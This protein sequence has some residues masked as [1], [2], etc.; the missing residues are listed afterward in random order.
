MSGVPSVE[1]FR[2]SLAEAA[3]ALA[4]LRRQG[5]LGEPPEGSPSWRVPAEAGTRVA[6]E[7]ARRRVAELERAL[8]E[9]LRGAESLAAENRR[10]TEEAAADEALEER[11]EEARARAADAEA[12]SKELRARAALLEAECVRLE[13]LRRKADGAAEEAAASG[14]AVAESL[15]REL[16]AAHAA[17]DR[18][19]SEAGHREAAVK[20]ETEALSKRL[21]TAVARLQS[22]E[23]E[24]RLEAARSAGDSSVVNGELE[25]AKAVGAALRAELA[26]FRVAAEREQLELRRE[27]AAVRRSVEDARSALEDRAAEIERARASAREQ[28]ERNAVELAELRAELARVRLN[29]GLEPEPEAAA[30]PDGGYV[31]PPVEPV[32]DPGWARLL[33]LVRPPVEAA[34]AHLRRLSATALAPGQKA[35]LRLAAASI[36][37]ATDSLSSVELS[38]EEE[39]GAPAAA[40]A[41]PVLEAA[42][43]AWEP[44]FRRRGVAL[45]RE[46]TAAVPD[47]AFEPKAMRLLLY[48]IL[49]NAL[50]ALPEGGRL[51]VRAGKSAD[52]GLKMEFIDDGPGFPSEWL[53][54][55]FEPFVSPRPGRPGLG[56]AIVRRTLRRWGADADAE[57]QPAG[58][59]RLTL[60]FAPPR[61]PSLPAA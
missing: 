6:L 5:G 43:V 32:L 28:A 14:Q 27:L 22:Q 2:R 7:D 44:A 37:Q 3:G 61:P 24:R 1:A 42:V 41:V 40:S 33:R 12:E 10:L 25:R 47:A 18:A 45:I 8:A 48:Q 50:E 36:A 39:P 16:R 21:E 31:Q 54:K 9:A 49:R 52:G 29:H 34:Y 58:G 23:R 56:L 26:G 4:E 60:R 57:N 15:G 19:S 35:L 30:E 20:T 11:A 55:R 38:L 53:A 46:W 13:S 59:A 17:L 51:A